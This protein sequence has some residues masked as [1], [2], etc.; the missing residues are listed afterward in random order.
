MASASM[1]STWLDEPRASLRL[2]LYL[3]VKPV[4]IVTGPP[5]V[6]V[7]RSIYAFLGSIQMAALSI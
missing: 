6:H 4:I 2:R 3:H 1:A 7:R 5:N